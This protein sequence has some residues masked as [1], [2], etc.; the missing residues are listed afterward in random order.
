VVEL[1]PG[2]GVVTQAI[3]ERGIAPSNLTS[4]EY[5]GD[6]A[7]LVRARFPEVTIVEGDAYDLASAA[8]AIIL[9]WPASSPACRCSR[10][11]CDRRAAR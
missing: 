8:S 1:G 2:T 7:K 4:I 9:R 10:R 5:C 11:P 6:F 3:L